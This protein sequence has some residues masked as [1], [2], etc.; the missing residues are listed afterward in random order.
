[1][2][3]T[4]PPNS[5]GPILDL[6]LPASDDAIDIVL[7]NKTTEKQL[8]I[9]L[10]EEWE[11]DLTLDFFRRAIKDAGGSDRSALLDPSDH[12]LW[13]PEPLIAGANDVD[14]EARTKNGKWIVD[15]A[16]PWWIASNASYIY[17]MS[18][19]NDIGRAKLDGSESDPKWL[20]TPALGRGLA[21]DGTYIYWADSVTDKIGRAKLD[22]SEIN[23]SFASVSSN[24]F[25]IAVDASY[26]Y[27]TDLS[28]ENIGRVKIDGS[29]PN[30]EWLKGV[31]DPRGITVDGSFIY[32]A[33][34]DSIARAKIGGTE[35]LQEWI[36]APSDV[37]DVA[38]DATHIYWVEGS[39]NERI[40]R[41]KLDATE[42]DPEWI[43]VPGL[44]D[45]RGVA[46]GAD[47]LY[48]GDIGGANNS[49][50]RASLS[51]PIEIGAT[52]RWE[53]GHY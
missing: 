26:I 33:Q 51:A 18:E 53:K 46:I 38:V 21:I 11:G 45:P 47:Y 44:A 30:A 12:E 22:G 48:W 13:V 31:N 32:I 3:I 2:S 36:T 6:T 9:N 14:L 49:I 35:L 1:L 27:W 34:D 5:R 24:P 25:Y 52:L 19:G 4:I 16:S 15:P 37:F 42:V 7:R 10:P 50:G 17:W 39:A 29:G 28:T 23:A 41:A 20:T 43:A 8:G 40:G